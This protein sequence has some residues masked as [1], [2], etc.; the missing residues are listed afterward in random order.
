M[1]Q[2]SPTSFGNDDA[3][4]LLL[5][6]EGAKSIDHVVSELKR[7]FDAY[8]AYEILR[9][10][11]ENLTV[12]TK[13]AVEHLISHYDPHAEGIEEFFDRLRNSVGTK[14][15]DDGGHEANASIA[16]AEV[17]YALSA[18]NFEQLPKDGRHLGRFSPTDL[19]DVISLAIGSLEQIS[20]NKLLSKTNGSKWSRN[21][22]SVLAKLQACHC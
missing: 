11:G 13:E 5:R 9:E 10:R 17:A 22:R 8:S 21:L 16:S 12:L 20:K 14:L 6:L 7:C 19:A 2:W 18:R 1:G 3:L 15:V 4:D